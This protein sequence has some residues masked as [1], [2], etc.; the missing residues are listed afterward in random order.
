M[1]FIRLLFA[2]SM[3]ALLLYLFD[4]RPAELPLLGKIEALKN[5][6][7]FAKFLNPF[8]GFWLNGE[9]TKPN[10]EITIKTELLQ[11]KVEILL[12]ER[13]V[14]H[15]FAKNEQDLY[16][17]QG[18][19]TAKYR[20]WQMEFQT[21]AAA[22]RLAEIIGE[23]VLD[24]DRYQYRIG[25]RKAAQLAL[26]EMHKDPITKQS[27][28]AYTNGVNAYITQLNPRDY[29]LEYKLLG[30][31]PEPW[32][33]IKSA[34]LLKYMAQDLSFQNYDLAL[35][36]V[37]EKFG[38][39]QTALI[40]PNYT[41][42]QS[43]IVPDEELEKFKKKDIPKRPKNYTA[44]LPLDTLAGLPEDKSG[45]GSNNWAVSAEKSATGYPILSNDPHLGL[46][47]PSIWFEVQL[48]SPKLN[49][50]GVSLPGAP[51]VI[52]GFNQD[53]AWGVT[54][55][56]PDVTDWYKITFKDKQRKQYKFGDTWKDTSFEIDTLKIKGGGYVLDTLLFTHHGPVVATLNHK[57]QT[58]LQNRAIPLESAL[59]WL[60]HEPS[61]DFLTFYQLNKAKNYQD[62]R[63]AISTYVCPAQNFVFADNQK[64]IAI[65]SQGKIPLKW[66]E[67]GKFVLDGSNP[68]HDWQDW[69]P[70]NQNPHVKNPQRGFVS[71]ANQFPVSDSLYPYYLHWEF[72]SYERGARINQRLAEMEKITPDS[73]RNLQNDAYGLFA[74]DVLPKLLASLSPDKLSKQEKQ[75]YDLLKTWD[76]YYHADK[77]APTIFKNWWDNFTEATWQ[78]ELN[79]DFIRYPSREHT[80]ILVNQ[81]DSLKPIKWFDNIETEKVE[82]LGD[83]ALL[84][85]QKTVKK[86]STLY[87]EINEQWQ[88]SNDRNLTIRHLARIPAFS[89][90]KVVSHGD[91]TT[92]NATGASSGPSWRMV[93]ALGQTP[94]AYGIYPGGQS[95][96]PGSIYYDNFIPAWSK[97]ELASLHYLKSTKVPE[98]VKIISRVK[99]EK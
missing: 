31:A 60:A 87:G 95:G 18:Y 78:D 91:K 42:K 1:K 36:R 99:M 97:G 81:E 77:I 40:F 54:N 20:L 19:I 8:G 9:A 65:T 55:V 15:I 37:L 35:T 61:N 70:S 44:P 13:L 4:N 64:D 53:I 50:Y 59:K 52:I 34:Y 71:S 66:K 29:P 22:G 30:Y 16:F 48:V 32:T 84:S 75:A 67:Q 90:S 94:E 3:T 43:P 83:I 24:F 62:Y 17:A 74:S 25:M 86:L 69:I 92:V 41:K 47:L 38:A 51:G 73:I 72:A 56:A 21:H 76:F 68:E 14:P 39:E 80:A 49:V 93:V 12:D 2:L 63:K 98:G 46:N 33:Q 96:N 88:W 7:S 89:Q 11:D 26:E 79:Q 58:W 6:P 85:F 23:P 27:L 28:E 82:N 45:I 10:E 57:N 5:A